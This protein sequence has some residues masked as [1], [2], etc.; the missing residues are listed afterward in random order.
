MS[1]DLEKETAKYRE[2]RKKIFTKENNDENSMTETT[3]V[4]QESN[5]YYPYSD[6]FMWSAFF[7]GPIVCYLAHLSDLKNISKSFFWY[8]FGVCF[9]PRGAFKFADKFI[10]QSMAG[11]TVNA[12]YIESR[13]YLYCLAEL[14]LVLFYNL[15]VALIA[16]S[17]FKQ[18]CPYCDIDKYDEH[19]KKGVIAGCILWLL[20]NVIMIFFI[21]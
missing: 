16:A 9:I 17:R 14:A 15:F 10:E 3:P 2:Q 19:E 18:V 21:K 7:G 5:A 13:F 12:S 4:E 11:F 20:M 1:F 6:M 8:V